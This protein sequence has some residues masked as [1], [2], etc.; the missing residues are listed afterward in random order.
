MRVLRPV[1]LCVHTRACACNVCVQALRQLCVG[2]LAVHGLCRNGF[3][4]DGFCASIPLNGG[5]YTVSIIGERPH[6]LIAYLFINICYI[7]LCLQKILFVCCFVLY[8]VVYLPQMVKELF[9]LLSSTCVQW[10][11]CSTE[12]VVLFMVLF[13]VFVSISCVFLCVNFIYKMCHFRANCAVCCVSFCDIVR[14]C[15]NTC[16]G[17]CCFKHLSE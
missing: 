12:I 1:S 8:F 9:M 4:Q 7:R 6:C 13:A 16:F 14:R 10:E 5:N 11:V 3:S 17:G 2:V 15:K